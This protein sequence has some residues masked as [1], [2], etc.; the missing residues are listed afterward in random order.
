[1][2]VKTEWWKWR[3]DTLNLQAQIFP[4]F[5][6][7]I[8]S[9]YAGLREDKDLDDDKDLVRYFSQFIKRRQENDDIWKQKTTFDM[10]QDRVQLAVAMWG[11][12]I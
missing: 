1:M 4:S 6:V 12:T 3:A 10:T 5:H 11:D 8:C 9:G 2:K 7:M